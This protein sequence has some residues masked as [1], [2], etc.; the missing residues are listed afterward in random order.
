M[1]KAMMM[2]TSWHLFSILFLW[3]DVAYV[4]VDIIQVSETDGREWCLE[5]V[6]YLEGHQNLSV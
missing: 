3:E 6:V 4:S 2:F 1:R 5:S